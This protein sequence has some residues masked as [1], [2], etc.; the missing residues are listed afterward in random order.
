[1]NRKERIDRVREEIR[2]LEAQHQALAAEAD[3]L[4]RRA[5]I[6]GEIAAKR[7]E[8]ERLRAKQ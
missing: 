2:L 7:R 4:P 6:E 8:L 1:V 3:L 5:Q